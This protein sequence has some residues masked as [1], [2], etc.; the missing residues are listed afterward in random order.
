MRLVSAIVVVCL[1]W[2]EAQSAFATD[3]KPYW[4][5]TIQESERFD[6]N[7]ISLLW[8]EQIKRDPLIPFCCRK[9]MGEYA[10]Q[11]KV[12]GGKI[13]LTL[14]EPEDSDPTDRKIT[15]YVKVKVR[16]GTLCLPL[17]AGE[18]RDQSANRIDDSPKGNSEFEQKVIFGTIRTAATNLI[19]SYNSYIGGVLFVVNTGKP[20]TKMEKLD[21]YSA[22]AFK[23][24]RRRLVEL[25]GEDAVG[26]LDQKLQFIDYFKEEDYGPLP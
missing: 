17:P 13:I 10:V 4:E 8:N 12:R 5:L 14:P 21:K 19:N 16:G 2:S 1:L 23:H 25:C 7:Q 24:R 6:R 22:A 9:R 3:V 18:P 20:G 26:E 11:V 15:E